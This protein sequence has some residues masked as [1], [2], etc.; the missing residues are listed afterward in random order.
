MQTLDAAQ[1]AALIRRGKSP[2]PGPVRGPLR[3]KGLP[4]RRLPA[5][6]QVDTLDLTDCTALTALPADLRVRRL[7]V[8]GC[9]ALT[10][11][12]AGL[13]CYELAARGTG[14]TGLPADLAVAYRLDLSDSPD[15]GSL[16]AG[17]RTGVLI[18][19]NCPRLVAL[20]E[21]LR[22]YFLDVAGCA[23]LAHWP[24][25]A[26]V[27]IG[28]A[29]LRGCRSLR[30]LPPAVRNLAWIDLADSGVTALPP[31][32]AG[33]GLRW[34]GIA[35]EQRHVFAPETITAAEVLRER[36]AER[37]RVILERMGYDA[38]LE[39]AHAEVLDSDRDA[40]GPR[41]L[42][43]VALE[44]DEPLV[45]LAVC[46]PSTGR[47]YMLRVPPAMRTARQAAAWIAGF[48]NPDDYAPLV[49]T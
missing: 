27:E 7:I 12:P 31:G 26:A 4:I 18:L 9:T 21:G 24:E 48:D 45:C 3:L 39:Q 2:P 44:D 11:L 20:P 46:C 13:R 38:F 28:C 35:V 8:S 47:Q 5:G 16:P 25:S 43:R 19:R 36:N 49:E 40:G 33:A 10:A 15:L 6:L 22:V 37:R 1:V 41:R 32:L 42:M 30:A 17:L 14:L 23:A 34:R 29:D